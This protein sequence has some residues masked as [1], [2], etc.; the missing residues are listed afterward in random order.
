MTGKCTLKTNL[1][2]DLKKL[3]PDSVKT[4]EACSALCDKDATCKAVQ[5]KSDGCTLFTETKKMIGNNIGT[6]KCAIK[7]KADNTASQTT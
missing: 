4:V 1:V 5:F 3:S 2:S 7:P 6:G